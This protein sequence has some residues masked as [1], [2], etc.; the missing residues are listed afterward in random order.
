MI[1]NGYGGI[2][3]PGMKPIILR[4]VNE[5]S[6][7]VKIPIIGCGGITCAADAGRFMDEGASLVQVYSGLVFRGPGL[8]KEISQGLSWRQRTWI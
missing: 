2:S 4:M 6:K 1:G 7:A 3:G 5:C 8:A